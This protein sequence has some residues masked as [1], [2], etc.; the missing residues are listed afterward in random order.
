MKVHCG[1]LC[2]DTSSCSWHTWKHQELNPE[3]FVSGVNL[4]NTHTHTHTPQIEAKNRKKQGVALFHHGSRSMKPYQAL[5]S[6]IGRWIF[7]MIRWAVDTR[8]IGFHE[9]HRSPEQFAASKLKG[10]ET[11][12]NKHNGNKKTHI[13]NYWETIND[14]GRI[15]KASGIS[16]NYIMLFSRF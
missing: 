3:P 6:K 5:N 14:T 1:F 4:K 7:P 13:K 10:W 11:T 12:Q 16:F 9:S 8:K 15:T 2:G